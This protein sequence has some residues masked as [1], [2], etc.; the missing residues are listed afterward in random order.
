MLGP[1]ILLGTALLLV[2]LVLSAVVA[3][4]AI[5]PP[6]RTAAYAVARGLPCDPGDAGLDFEAWTL[7]RPDGARLAVWDVT[8]GETTRERDDETENGLVVV[9]VHGWGQSKID[10]LV[11]RSPYDAFADRMIFY[12]LRGHG[13]SEGSSSRL[14][15]KEEDDLIEL[16]DRTCD[17]RE[18]LLVGHSTGAVIAIAAAAKMRAAGDHHVRGIVCYSAYTSTIVP[19]S[20]RLR[21]LRQPWVVIPELALLL[22]RGFGI[23][24][25]QPR[26]SITQVETPILIIHGQEDHITP[27]DEIA[28]LIEGAANVQVRTL[29]GVGHSDVHDKAP[30][31]HDAIVRAFLCERGAGSR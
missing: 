28:R 12:D 18:V 25:V 31:E 14:G 22:L 29:T 21:A 4:E 23:R 3:W 30:R 24:D 16:L 26:R 10:T 20:N 17:G 13:E 11:R 7:D 1:L 8:N 15:W 6:R 5:H 19:V 2:V 27:E 9:F